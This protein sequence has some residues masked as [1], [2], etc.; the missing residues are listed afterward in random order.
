MSA[1]CP[2]RWTGISARVRGVV[3]GAEAE[4][5]QRRQ[6]RVGTGRHT[7]RVLDAQIGLQIAFEP[8]HFG[9]VDEALA[10]TDARDCLEERVAQWRVLRL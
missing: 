8:F 5:H 4:R 9:A 3:A 1:D 2:N 7:N 6:H 10:I